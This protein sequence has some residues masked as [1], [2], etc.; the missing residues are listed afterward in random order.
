VADLHMKSMVA[1]VG[2][3]PSTVVKMGGGIDFGVLTCGVSTNEVPFGIAQNWTEG[4][5][6]TPYDTGFAASAGKRIMVWAPGATA[7]AAVQ[8]QGANLPAGSPVG[9]DTLGE[10]VAVTS[11]W[12][13]G[14]LVESG[15]LTQRWRLRIY[16]H[17]MRLN[18]GS[19][20]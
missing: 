15:S 11:G 7:V 16:V 4:P 6:G 18:T 14:Y 8:L 5:P 2:I 1:A 13:V 20:S 3:K 19:T 9:P 10:I 17:P 12:A